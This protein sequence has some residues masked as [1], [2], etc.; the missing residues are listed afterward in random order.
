MDRSRGRLGPTCLRAL[1]IGIQAASVFV[2]QSILYSQN[3]PKYKHFPVCFFKK[4]ALWSLLW[5]WFNY[6]KAKL[7]AK[8][9]LQE[10]SLL[11]NTKSP[12]VQVLIGENSLFW[13]QIL[14]FLCYFTGTVCGL[15]CSLGNAKT[16]KAPCFSYLVSNILF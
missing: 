8:E 2:K 13:F 4:E 7:Q 1:V 5:I 9:P 6:V 16:N 14:S 3:L 12:D 10:A 15:N 11:L